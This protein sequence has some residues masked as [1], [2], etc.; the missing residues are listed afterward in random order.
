L[1]LDEGLVHRLIIN[2]NEIEVEKLHDKV[3]VFKNAFKGSADMIDYYLKNH[4]HTQTEWYEFGHHIIIPLNGDTWDSFPSQEDWTE[5]HSNGEFKKDSASKNIYVEELL[6][7]FYDASKNY[8]ESV[9]VDYPNF[10]FDSVDIAYYKDGIGTNEYQGMSYHTDFQQE[11]KE[12]PGLK[13]GTTCL[14]YLNDNYDGGEINIIEL[15][16]D[17]EDLIS[18]IE[19]KP[20]SGD[21]LVFPSGH[22]FYHSPMI[23][24]N[25]IKYLIRT[26]WKYEYPGSDAWHLEKSQH[27]EDEW[28]EILRERHKERSLTSGQ[29]LN[30]WN[31]LHWDGKS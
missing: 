7:V 30:K 27:T 12:D 16:D 28:K 24:R 8:F 18:K 20:G 4:L 14:F 2:G 3:W 17:K 5:T 19:Y 11:R 13:F 22:P 15:T 10:K 31:Q 25:G 21:L 29:S 1:A 9:D 26:Y 6:Q 23:A